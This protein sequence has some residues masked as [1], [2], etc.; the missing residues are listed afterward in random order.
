[1]STIKIPS[2]D[3]M[4][5]KRE[6]ELGSKDRFD[7]AASEDITFSIL[8]PR[9]M[10]DDQRDELA[11]LRRDLESGEILPS[12]FADGY[13][14]MYL[15]DQVDEFLDVGGTSAILT[16]VISAYVEQMDPTRRSSR[17]TRRRS[18]RR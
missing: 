7:W 11:L 13:L 2:L 17:T 3:T 1:M 10:T 14:E 18:K 5:A 9:L 4:L 6:E 16:E 12:E 8:D 15:D